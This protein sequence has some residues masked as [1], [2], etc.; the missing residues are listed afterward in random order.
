VSQDLLPRVAGVALLDELDQV[1]EQ[2]NPHR[3]SFWDALREGMSLPRWYRFPEQAVVSDGLRWYRLDDEHGILIGRLDPY[4][5]FVP[6]ELMDR[7]TLTAK[8][9][10]KGMRR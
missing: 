10:P 4:G 2:T 8:P 9:L 5:E 1:L 6:T 7:D 3:P